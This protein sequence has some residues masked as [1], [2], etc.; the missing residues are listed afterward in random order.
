VR[1]LGDPRGL[2]D[3]LGERLARTVEHQRGEAAVERFLAFL[4]RCSRDRDARRPER[5]RFRQ[6]PEHRAKHGS[7]VC[8]ARRAGLQDHRRALGLA[9]G[10]IGAHVLPAERDQTPPPHSPASAPAEGPPRVLP[11]SFELG[12]HVLDARDRLDLRGM[13]G[14]EILHQRALA[15]PAKDGEIIHLVARQHAAGVVALVEADRRAVDDVVGVAR[16][17]VDALQHL[18]AGAVIRPEAEIVGLVMPGLIG[19]TVGVVLVAGKPRPAALPHG[20]QLADQ[21][22][23]NLVVLLLA[24]DVLD[25]AVRLGVVRAVLHQVQPSARTAKGSSTFRRIWRRR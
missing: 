4:D 24:E 13:G 25:L 22:T 3:V 16:L 1:H 15:E 12:D 5:T 23:T 6:M 2:V 19:Q 10:H 8:A 21:Q 18:H 7:G 14:L 17:V 20:E 11:V 9:G